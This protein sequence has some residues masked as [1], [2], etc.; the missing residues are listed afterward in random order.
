MKPS[1]LSRAAGIAR[2]VG[3]AAAGRRVPLIASWNVT[4]RCNLRCAYCG[5][6]RPGVREA[7]TDEALRVLRELAAL[8]TRYVG[9][10]GGEPF[11]RADL[12]TIVGAAADLGMQVRV[13]TNG[14]LAA[15]RIGEVR[16]AAEVQVSLDGPADV[17]DA[18]RG[19]GVFAAVEATVAACRDA[20][21]AVLADTVLSAANVGR[22]DDL[23]ATLDRLGIGTY[24]QP[25]DAAYAGERDGAGALFPDP[26]ACR[27]AIDGL[28]EHRRTGGRAVANSVSGLRHLR[29]WPDLPPLP[30]AVWRLMVA[31]DPDGAIGTCDMA[32]GY[33]QGLVRGAASVREAVASLPRD[34][35]CPRCGTGAGIDF[36]LAARGDPGALLG[37]LVRRLVA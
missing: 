19:E 33:E 3:L 28:I 18:V 27:A 32:P 26:A 14:T 6:C 12:G 10:S 35:R 23:L 24:V 36:N 2:A 37:M 11:V 1:D 5:V 21:I 7:G 25:I 15:G 31:V 17:H 34:C 16:R 20:G 9:L 13:Q 29:S 22:I 4:F 8:G 30:C